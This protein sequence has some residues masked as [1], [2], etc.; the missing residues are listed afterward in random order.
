MPDIKFCV[1]NSSVTP[2]A[3]FTAETA[4]ITCDL[5]EIP[6]DNCRIALICYAQVTTTAGT[7]N[8]TP[9]LRRGVGTAGALVG[10]RNAE[11]IKAAA[12]STES[13][14]FV[15]VDNLLTSAPLQYTFTLSAA[16]GNIAPQQY[17]I[18]AFVL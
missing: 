7:T 16:G 10:V 8:V 9:G 13:F 6:N 1:A 5:I 2:I 14:M 12:G 3:G 11:V 17:S 18:F 15:G 4:V